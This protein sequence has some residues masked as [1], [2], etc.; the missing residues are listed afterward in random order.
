[1][2]IYTVKRGDIAVKKLLAVFCAVCIV[3][4]LSGCS[5]L[6]GNIDT[7]LAPPAPTG[8]LREV[9]LALE[10]SVSDKI[11][12]KYPTSGDYR[13]AIVLK[14][15]NGD[16]TEEALALYSTT[17][18]NTT[19]MHINLIANNGEEWVSGGA[20]SL[21]AT[22]VEKIDFADMNGDGV[23]EILVGWSIYGT[24]EKS[25][26]VYSVTD[27]G[28]TSRI[29]ESYTSYIYRDFN[30]DDTPDILTIYQ[31]TAKSVSTAKLLDLTEDGT[32]VLGTCPL[33]PAVTEYREPIIFE[34]NGKIAVYLDGTKGTGTV[35]E[36][37]IIDSGMTNLS[38]SADTTTAFD[39]YRS[40]N[41][42]TT[43]I[44]S[45][46]NY[47]IPISF[48]L[49]ESAT[50]NAD[51]IYKTNWYC[52][53]G[54]GIVLTMSALMN[55]QDGYFLEI[56]EK[57]DSGVTVTSNSAERLRTVFRLDKESGN[58][59]EELLKIQAVPKA[60]G[61]ASTHADSIKIGEN[62]KYTYYAV[63]GTY[64]GA[65]AL[66]IDELKELF[67]IIS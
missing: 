34:L 30:N 11:T 14:D 65:E 35:T 62:D 38:F 37:L 63:F 36:M 32:A 48:L 3:L 41:T 55:Y 51:K 31:D 22:G 26:G 44:D 67:K 16:G 19:N 4:S 57:W 8:K 20:A 50:G 15:L 46:G 7:L 56:P 23:L 10:A 13:S 12:L 59:A 58:S 54:E 9:Q 24:V 40:G 25:L 18:D 64:T 39:T 52:Y 27:G 21:V 2:Y 43:D 60:N 28:I 17:L 1:M 5:M 47:D 29:L 42:A 33:D 45:D 49:T 6:D 61:T 66:S 53:N